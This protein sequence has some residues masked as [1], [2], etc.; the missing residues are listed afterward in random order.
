MTFART[1]AITKRIV[2]Q[3][4]LDHRSLAMIFAA[5]LVVMSLV[6]ASFNKNPQ[7]LN[8][9]EHHIGSHHFYVLRYYL[10][11]LEL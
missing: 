3:I 10:F 4:L 7:L 8:F 2:K 5:P 1:I 9:F 11:R 6:G